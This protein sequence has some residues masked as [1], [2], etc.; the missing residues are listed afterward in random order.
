MQRHAACICI[1]IQL[2][3]NSIM[4]TRAANVSTGRQLV[5][6]ASLFSKMVCVLIRS[7]PPNHPGAGLQLSFQAPAKPKVP[8]LTSLRLKLSTLFHF[9]RA[10]TSYHAIGGKP[11]F[12]R[13]FGFFGTRG[14]I[15][16]AVQPVFLPASDEHSLTNVESQSGFTIYGHPHTS[17]QSV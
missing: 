4:C 11:P 14:G 15:K 3:R 16:L 1:F 5:L 17:T 7:V 10:Y 2:K 9:L 13:V 12:R 6:T 8:S